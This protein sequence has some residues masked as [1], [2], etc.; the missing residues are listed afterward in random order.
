MAGTA[1]SIVSKWEFEKYE[2]TET[3][4]KFLLIPN[5]TAVIVSQENKILWL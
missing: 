4:S 1:S 5:I 2:V 3:F